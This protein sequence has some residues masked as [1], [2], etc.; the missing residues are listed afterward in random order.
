MENHIKRPLE[1][2]KGPAVLRTWVWDADV[3]STLFIVGSR[4]ELRVERDGIV[5][6][7]G[8]FNTVRRALEAAQEW[9]VEYD[10]QRTQ[11]G[12]TSAVAIP[13]PE[14]R[15]EIPV[16]ARARDGHRLYCQACGHVW[17]LDRAY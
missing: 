6:R 13:C 11:C 9:R 3:H 12:D 17:K 16:D 10:L 5:I 15:D 4:V 1:T 14:C 7:R 8:Q 2:S